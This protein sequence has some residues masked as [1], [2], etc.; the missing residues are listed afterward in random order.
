MDE[1]YDRQEGVVTFQ[2]LKT[3]KEERTTAERAGTGTRVAPQ[4][5][6]SAKKKKPAGRGFVAF[7][8]IGIIGIG[9][10]GATATAGPGAWVVAI[11]LVAL[12]AKWAG[13]FD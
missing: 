11:I 13:M 2:E 10:V 1:N 7:F 5:P 6:A 4:T 12:I 9:A 8:L 3:E